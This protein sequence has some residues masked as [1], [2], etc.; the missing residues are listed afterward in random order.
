MDDKMIQ[1][2]TK[3]IEENLAGE[4]SAPVIWLH[5]NARRQMEKLQL[6]HADISLRAHSVRTL[7]EHGCIK[8][9]EVA[10]AYLLFTERMQSVLMAYDEIARMSL[11]DELDLALED[12]PSGK[13]VVF[14]DQLA[15]ALAAHPNAAA[16]LLGL[17]EELVAWYGT[18]VRLVLT[19]KLGCTE[20][21]EACGA[22]VIPDSTLDIPMELE[23]MEAVRRETQAETIHWM[24]DLL[25]ECGGLPFIMSGNVAN[26]ANVPSR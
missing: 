4:G 25:Q 11:R 12:A 23:Q 21:A 6:R 16:S 15:T 7:A 26:A 13:L 8:S 10:M 9:A 22:K 3:M 1:N 17:G 24:V 18:R 20:I 2:T 19:D 14:V 5:G